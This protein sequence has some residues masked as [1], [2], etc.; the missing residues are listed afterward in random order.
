VAGRHP[1]E[2]AEH[3]RRLVAGPLGRRRARAPLRAT[4]DGGLTWSTTPIPKITQCSGGNAGNGGSY[5]RATDPFLSFAPNGD[6]YRL[7]LSFNDIFPSLTAFDFDH[8]LLVSK[9]TNGGSTGGP[10]DHRA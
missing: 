2:R 8:A 1:G 7:S 4:F 3:G 10:E 9:S 5:Q 6:V